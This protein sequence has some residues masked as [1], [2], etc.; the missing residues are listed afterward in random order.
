MPSN[1]LWA[2]ERGWAQCHFISSAERTLGAELDE[3]IAEMLRR[4]ASAL[5]ARN[6]RF[7]NVTRAKSACEPTVDL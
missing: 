6:C 7:G 1:G 4:R 3:M 2:R 5:D